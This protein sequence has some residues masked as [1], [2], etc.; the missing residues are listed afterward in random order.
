MCSSIHEYIYNVVLK[1]VIVLVKIFTFH[2]MYS[3]LPYLTFGVGHSKKKTARA[4][5]N[6]I[7]LKML[8]TDQSNEGKL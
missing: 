5:Q 7:L 6:D 3:E 2:P 4:L 1:V 8:F